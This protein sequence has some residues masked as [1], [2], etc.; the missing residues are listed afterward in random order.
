MTDLL[1]ILLD[2][3]ITTWVI[4]GFIIFMINYIDF[5]FANIRNPAKRMIYASF[6]GPIAFIICLS[7]IL[8]KVFVKQIDFI[9]KI[10]ESYCN[11]IKL[12]LIK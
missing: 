11:K 12:W 8:A 6:F 1:H 2:M 9:R 5:A 7:I 4:A 3:F 10:I